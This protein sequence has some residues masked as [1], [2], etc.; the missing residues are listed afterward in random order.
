M[1]FPLSDER[2]DTEWVI[3]PTKGIN[4]LTSHSDINITIN[5]EG[6]FVS[7]RALK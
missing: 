7:K 1:N 6:L 3:Y 2:Y 5:K 4:K